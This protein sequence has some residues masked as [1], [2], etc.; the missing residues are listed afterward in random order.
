MS[1]K[2]V[3]IILSCIIS[4]SVA[5]Y[6]IP[7]VTFQSNTAVTVLPGTDFTFT[8]ELKNTGTTIGYLPV[9]DLLFEANGLTLEGDGSTM[10]NGI[11]N[12]VPY[13]YQFITN[14]CILHPYVKYHPTSNSSLTAICGTAG[15][16]FFS[17][18]TSILSIGA[19]ISF[20]LTHTATLIAGKSTGKIKTRG[21]FEYASYT[22]SQT[23]NDGVVSDWASM[24]VTKK[25][26]EPTL[27]F[28][29][30][31]WVIGPEAWH[32][33]HYDII[34]SPDIS[35]IS[36]EIV[37]PIPCGVHLPAAGDSVGLFETPLAT[38]LSYVVSA[39]KKKLTITWNFA[40]GTTYPVGSLPPNPPTLTTLLTA[41]SIHFHFRVDGKT[42]DG[43]Y[44]PG[45]GNGSPIVLQWSILNT[46]RTYEIDCHCIGG[47]TE[48]SSGSTQASTLFAE[49]SN[50]P[51]GVIVPSAT[52][53][54]NFGFFIP[55][56]ACLLLPSDD[57]V[58]VSDVLADGY[59]LVPPVSI[60][61]GTQLIALSD[62]AYLIENY[63]NQPVHVSVDLLAVPALQQYILPVS[64][65]D[66]RKTLKG[67]ALFATGVN[68][69]AK[70][71]IRQK[72]RVDG[73]TIYHGESLDSTVSVSGDSYECS[74]GPSGQLKRASST[75]S[76]TIPCPSL[77]HTLVSIDPVSPGQK[78][79]WKLTYVLP[80]DRDIK[81][82]KFTIG[83]AYPI[84][85]VSDF[86]STAVESQTSGV[87][88]DATNDPR[89]GRVVYG[90][91]SWKIGIS[92]TKT[93]ET[94]GNSLT[95]T[96]QDYVDAGTSPAVI[97]LYYALTARD[98]LYPDGALFT[99]TVSS[100]EY[101]D[102]IGSIISSFHM[103]FPTLSFDKHAVTSILTNPTNRA[104]VNS[105]DAT[106]IDGTTCYQAETTIF[107]S[108]SGYAYNVGVD[109]GIPL[110]Y[111]LDTTTKVSVKNGHKFTQTTTGAKLTSPIPSDNGVTFTYKVCAI[112]TLPY[113]IATSKASVTYF[114]SNPSGAN[115]VQDSNYS[116]IVSSIYKLTSRSV[117]VT[118]LT[119]STSCDTTFG[120][121]LA[122]GEKAT[123]T[124]TVVIPPGST[125]Q[126]SLSHA[127]KSLIFETASVVPKTSQSFNYAL[128]TTTGNVV[129][130]N[131]VINTQTTD[132]NLILTLVV[133]A[134][135]SVT[136]ANGVNLNDLV[137]VTDVTGTYTSKCDFNLLNPLV[138]QTVTRSSKT[139]IDGL[140]V[141]TYEAS[142]KNS[143]TNA[144]RVTTV[145]ALPTEL[146]TVVVKKQPPVG[147]FKY[148]QTSKKFSLSI[149]NM[150]VDQVASFT[151]ETTVI[152]Q[153]DAGVTINPILTGYYTSTNSDPTANFTLA[154][155]ATSSA[156]TFTE[157]DATI[158]VI[159]PDSTALST[160]TPCTTGETPLVVG[161]TTRFCYAV[162]LFEG[163]T[164]NLAVTLAFPQ[165]TNAVL[166]ILPASVA[167]TKS[168][169]ITYSTPTIS[170]TDPF[171]DGVNANGQVV[172]TFS[173]VT[174]TPNSANDDTITVCA[175]AKVLNNDLSVDTGKPFTLTGSIT[176]KQQPALVSAKLTRTITYEIV[177]PI[178]T[179]SYDSTSTADGAVVSG[180]DRVTYKYQIAHKTGTGCD[181]S[182]AAARN[183]VITASVAG[184][185]V[186]GSPINAKLTSSSGKTINV[187]L[188]SNFVLT[189]TIDTMALSE[190]YTLSFEAKIKSTAIPNKSI[191]SA[192]ISYQS[193]TTTEARTYTENT[194]RGVT[195]KT[196]T[197]TVDDVPQ[198]N[199]PETTD[200]NAL[201][202]G[203]TST[204]KACVTFP[205]LV[206]N[207]PSVKISSPNVALLKVTAASVLSSGAG[208]TDSPSTTISSDGSYV[209]FTFGKS[210][211]RPCDTLDTRYTTCF[212]IGTTLLP[213][214]I[215]TNGHQLAVTG[216]LTVSGIVVSIDNNNFVVVYRRLLGD[217]VW[218]DKNFDGFQNPSEPG[219]GNVKM[220][221]K[222][223]GT[224]TIT[225]A[226]TAA[227]GYYGF[228]ILP[229]HRYQVSFSNSDVPTTTACGVTPL[230]TLYGYYIDASNSKGRAVTP[231]SLTTIIQSD[232]VTAP[233]T[234]PDTGITN[235]DF[236]LRERIDVGDY[237]WCD[238]NYD[239]LQSIGE[240]GIAGVV[241]S[242][243]D[244]SSGDPVFVKSATTDST[245]HYKIYD[246][247]S[248]N[249]Y[250]ISVDL[251]QSVLG[252][253]NVPSKTG[254]T[255][256]DQNN[257]AVAL[258]DIISPLF[259]AVPVKVS[260]HTDLTV[261]DIGLHNRIDL[262]S[263]IWCDVNNDG[264]Q[265][266]TFTIDYPLPGVEVTVS[267]ESRTAT[268]TSDNRG[269]I[270]LTNL[271]PQEQVT[272]SISTTSPANLNAFKKCKIPTFHYKDVND[273]INSDGIADNWLTPTLS[274]VVFVPAASATGP[275]VL[276]YDF[277]FRQEINVG[278]Y[279][280][281]DVNVDGLQSGHDIPLSGVIVQLY[282]LDTHKIDKATTD[283]QGYFV[284][285]NIPP[286]HNLNVYIQLNDPNLGTCNIPTIPASGSPTTDSNGVLNT[287]ETPH[288]S[289]VTLS[290]PL[291]PVEDFMTFDFGFRTSIDIGDYVWCDYDMDGK[292]DL[293]D[294]PLVDVTV[295]LLSD[296]DTV[297]TTTNE[298][299]QYYF[300]DLSPNTPYQIIVSRFDI[301][302]PC[303]YPTQ[304]LADSPQTGSKGIPDTTT[305]PSKSTIHYKFTTPSTTGTTVNYDQDF[306]FIE[307]RRNAGIEL[308]AT[309][310]KDGSLCG[311]KD[312]MQLCACDLEPVVFCYTVRNTGGSIIY[313]ITVTDD[314]ATPDDYSDDVELKIEELGV[315]EQ[316]I[317]THT[318]SISGIGVSTFGAWAVGKDRPSTPAIDI[319]T[320]EK[321]VVVDILD[322]S[323]LVFVRHELTSAIQ[324]MIPHT[325]K[326]TK[327]QSIILPLWKPEWLGGTEN[328]LLH[329]AVQLPVYDETNEGYCYFSTGSGDYSL[330][331]THYAKLIRGVTIKIFLIDFVIPDDSSVS[332]IFVEAWKLS[333]VPLC[334]LEAELAKS[335]VKF[336]V[337]KG[338]LLREFIPIFRLAFDSCAT[339]ILDNTFVES[340]I[341]DILARTSTIPLFAN[342]VFSE[343]AKTR[344]W[345]VYLNIE[346]YSYFREAVSPDLLEVFD[347]TA[348]LSEFS[349]IDG[350]FIPE[351]YGVRYA[352]HIILPS[353]G[354]V[355][356]LLT[357]SSE[358]L[359]FPYYGKLRKELF[360]AIAYGK[361]T[362]LLVPLDTER[363]SYLE[364]LPSNVEL[365]GCELNSLKLQAKDILR[366]RYPT[367]YC[368]NSPTRW[369]IWNSDLDYFE[370]RTALETYVNEFYDYGVCLI[371]ASGVSCEVA[372]NELLTRL[373]DEHKIIWI[374]ESDSPNVQL[375]LFAADFGFIPAVTSA[376][377]LVAFKNLLA[378]NPLLTTG[379]GALGDVIRVRTETPSLVKFRTQ[380]SQHVTSTASL[381]A[382]IADLNLCPSIT[383]LPQAY[384]F[385]FL[386][387]PIYADTPNLASF[388][389]QLEALLG[390]LNFLDELGCSFT[391]DYRR[392]LVME[393]SCYSWN[394][395]TSMTNEVNKLY[396]CT[397]AVPSPLPTLDTI[398]AHLV[399][400]F[401]ESSQH[402]M[403]CSDQWIID[404]SLS[405]D[406]LLY[407]VLKNVY[408]FGGSQSVLL[409]SYTNDVVVSRHV[410]ANILSDTYFPSLYCIFNNGEDRLLSLVVDNTYQT[411]SMALPN[412][413][414]SQKYSVKDQVEEALDVLHSNNLCHG[415]IQN[416]VLV[417]FDGDY[418]NVILVNEI[419]SPDDEEDCIFK[420]NTD[421]FSFSLTF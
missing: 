14:E 310:S 103:S 12:I 353:P 125:S 400:T 225:Q 168:T 120:S 98:R 104:V 374:Q 193:W 188:K 321:S 255:P 153:P 265:D 56:T 279:V 140:D 162:T 117:S 176:Y 292:Q 118:C 308:N 126:L 293:S 174:N 47:Y 78:T 376:W 131:G 155:P 343:Y 107:N 380:L 73:S 18:K 96:V 227:D 66:S 111:V 30:N 80:N 344:A 8:I 22:S 206:S 245:G 324:S 211:S 399:D 134:S 290:I 37:I 218:C 166:D 347:V 294:R 396:S 145:L 109:F 354:L 112:S 406:G 268:L 82:L 303:N 75:S 331:Y 335:T 362:G 210:I 379:V 421:W 366:K 148:D 101:R 307:P 251:S 85:S 373:S 167:V 264:L 63:P 314:N 389:D 333:L 249:K 367:Q 127:L 291:Y 266:T 50:N 415:N 337:G 287:D 286:G 219:I 414:T 34:L 395:P 53:N 7:S 305:N 332:E 364:S 157:C 330:E 61:V 4:L 226:N 10:L 240:N 328:T 408:A 114:S 295:T 175:D 386:P 363:F 285:S 58:F 5:Q 418:V 348:D 113:G 338:K 263:F 9:V 253:C 199:Y 239:G 198:T 149:V 356:L 36:G 236:G 165:P 352:H 200:S 383:F 196:A 319:V 178:L 410:V 284:F 241:V 377:P 350:Y 88:I 315:R 342:F 223:I 250:Q 420:D 70:T 52:V 97:E 203:E 235:V 234:I 282:D 215:N 357:Q 90:Q 205:T 369:A 185:I 151:F 209:T 326:V 283:E 359:P 84:L 27:V 44:C 197:L 92:V 173:D 299:G 267:S 190:Q 222:D 152:A 3:C 345:K 232:I 327:T 194:S 336:G 94:T 25:V 163:R 407:G 33:C 201:A 244:L 275:F 385:S 349:T 273:N 269:R 259:A 300:Y 262:S 65:T 60:Q 76:V 370:G 16:T 128:T 81:G 301:H 31:G 55:K 368:S 26:S 311:Y 68:F 28:P 413:S 184:E 254:S 207:S 403:E 108:G 312:E 401:L 419:D 276:E 318:R 237:V 161:E 35:L 309:V 40:P 23:F 169:P 365:S 246:I 341:V 77:T 238:T 271:V 41:L 358:L 340:T 79:V 258:P 204:W 38:G 154:P 1:L 150:P 252:R 351:L 180:C 230:P 212:S 6:P 394:S 48:G 375:A 220:S 13:Q 392:S 372:F 216:T 231:N 405:P 32:R 270:F 172:V 242:L 64:A 171:N 143:N 177:R 296:R 170:V 272:I 397:A 100:S 83:F 257:D 156:Y 229:G 54:H 110:N 325:D 281:C 164:Q 416:G 138:V 106:G 280:W 302:E 355:E 133:S 122:G 45:V 182:L 192:T 390:D 313:K 142:I 317:L 384:V 132:L 306:G 24:T 46:F 147:T 102:C 139:C 382:W 136:L 388:W 274:S 323:H 159:T 417:S 42:D 15:Q 62:T 124:I 116:P 412:L 387:A 187:V 228:D 208:I 195:L 95:L 261:G 214:P 119:T 361:A 59:D 72:H 298:H 329:G 135:T 17:F 288:Q 320:A 67:D 248:G 29:D 144:Y 221:M 346:D 189:A 289:F 179:L 247:V 146:G 322:C 360:L 297:Y 381:D 43:Q 391:N 86:V 121:N 191:T 213:S 11:G 21:A 316:V 39:D 260:D 217:F 304:V 183:V 115:L 278:N 160:R 99:V 243:N 123:L 186:D 256:G 409:T 339:Q 129:F 2:T 89:V 74:K 378:G 91:N 334:N 233:T 137:S 141:L 371:I 69:V 87:N 51:T 57:K 105:P 158:S 404:L 181:K 130:S 398:P 202:I 93:T 402:V 393:G 19:G 20:R 49:R 224:G 277:G 411:L 71:T